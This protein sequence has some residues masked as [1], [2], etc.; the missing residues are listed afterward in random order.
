VT[1]DPNRLEQIVMEKRDASGH[2]VYL[3]RGVVDGM[4]NLL[5]EQ[6]ERIERL[7][8]E[9]AAKIAELKKLLHTTNE[10]YKATMESNK[11]AAIICGELRAENERLRN[12]VLNVS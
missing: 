10:A 1:F 8:R 4:L 12:E 3:A 2:F 5:K 6:R 7:E 9:N 11:G